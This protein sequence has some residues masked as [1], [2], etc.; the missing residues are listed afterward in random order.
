MH[1][2][3]HR[4][5]A[6]AKIH[7]ARKLELYRAVRQG[8]GADSRLRDRRYPLVRR[9]REDAG[10]VPVRPGCQHRSGRPHQAL[11]IP[12]DQRAEAHRRIRKR[13]VRHAQEVHQLRAR[14]L[15]IRHARR[16]E[17]SSIHARVDILPLQVG[18]HPEATTSLATRYSNNANNVTL[19][20]ASR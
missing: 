13:E 16:R 2:R 7:E 6:R 4:R 3:M 10:D 8:R 14:A 15:G 17:H 9:L 12:G 1:R 20:E 18:F 5:V 19:N 11:D